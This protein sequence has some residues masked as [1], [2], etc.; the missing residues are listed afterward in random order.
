MR[1][2]QAAG[3]TRDKY[4]TNALG[5]SVEMSAFERASFVDH[6]RRAAL[7]LPDN[8][9][10]RREVVGARSPE[11]TATLLEKSAIRDTSFV[12]KMLDGGPDALR[13][14]GDPAVRM[15]LSL[16]PCCGPRRSST[17]G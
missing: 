17:G 7:W 1:A 12:R 9:V 8:D 16:P 11:V 10:Y 14:S 2:V 13:E 4:A 15:A 6:L 5:M 3:Q